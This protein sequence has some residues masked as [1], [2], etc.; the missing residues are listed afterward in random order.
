MDSFK[1]ISKVKGLIKELFHVANK[2]NA[3][4]A[5]LIEDWCNKSRLSLLS[6]SLSLSII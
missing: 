4:P 3:K 1:L 5:K 2:E 6:L